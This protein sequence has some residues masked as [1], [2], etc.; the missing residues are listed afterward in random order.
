MTFYPLE[1]LIEKRAEYELRMFWITDITYGIANNDY[2]GPT[3]EAICDIY[4]K[5]L[6]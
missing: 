5:L 4:R 1:F 6:P 2:L 3:A